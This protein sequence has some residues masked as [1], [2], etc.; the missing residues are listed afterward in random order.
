MGHTRR[1]LACVLVSSACTAC[2]SGGDPSEA[3]PPPPNREPVV[4]AGVDQ[5]VD[6]GEFVTLRG[7]VTDPDSTPVVS[8]TQTQGPGVVLTNEDRVDA[9]FTAPDVEDD[10][11]LRFTLTA[12][13][14]VNP[15]VSDSVEVLVRDIGVVIRRVS[16]SGRAYIDHEIHPDA[17][18]LVFLSQSEVWTGEIDP[19]TGLFV[20]EEGLDV[21]IDADATRLDRARNGP[22]YGRDAAGISIFYNRTAPDGAIE[23]WRA[24]TDGRTKTRIS[25]IGAD[26]FNPLPSRDSAAASTQ[27]AYAVFGPDGRPGHIGD[28]VVLDEDSGVETRLTSVRASLAGF[29]WIDDGPELAYTV[30]EGADEGQIALYDASSGATR[31]VTKDSGVKFDPFPWR[32][33]EYDD[34]LAVL[35][36]VNDRDIAVYLDRGDPHFERLV[37]LHPPAESGLDFVQSPEPFVYEGRSYI[38]LT[39]KDDP[40]PI[41][42]DVTNAQIWIYGL[43]ANANGVASTR[44]RCDDGLSNRIRT[45]G[46]VRVSPDGALQGFYNELE[47][48]GLYSIRLCRAGFALSERT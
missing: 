18:E 1:M 39:L 12:D 33:P 17:P 46:E 8:W 10:T 16:P 32:A 37:R 5:R 29:R 45:E 40:G 2:G 28:L 23:I 30:S 6:E 9:G 43:E 7:Q 19:Q 4:D 47:A 36:I 14:G 22:E 25:P 31:V 42:T 11:Q 20:T 44:L 13:D 41:A 24:E 21:L 38:V 15:P 3:P 48:S 35:A 27:V 34:A 26:R